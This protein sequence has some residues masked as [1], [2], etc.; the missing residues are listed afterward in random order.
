M[1]EMRENIINRLYLIADYVTEI[2]F[3][4]KW[5]FWQCAFVKLAN[6]IDS[7]AWLVMTEAMKNSPAKAA[8]PNAVDQPPRTAE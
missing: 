3:S 7:I 1:D 4:K 2:A 5:H 8:Q 6:A